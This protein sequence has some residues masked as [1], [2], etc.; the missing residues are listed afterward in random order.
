MIWNCSSLGLQFKVTFAFRRTKRKSFNV[1]VIASDLPKKMQNEVVSLI[2]EILMQSGSEFLSV[3]EIGMRMDAKYGPF[4]Q[5]FSYMADAD[6]GF[7]RHAKHSILLEIDEEI[8]VLIYLA[9]GGGSDF[10][11]IFGLVDWLLQY[12]C[13]SKVHSIILLFTR[14]YFKNYLYYHDNCTARVQY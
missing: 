13:G 3:G 10:W 8:R 7:A 5:V 11:Y 12:L 14:R 6:V 2:E 4:W 9:G 1:E